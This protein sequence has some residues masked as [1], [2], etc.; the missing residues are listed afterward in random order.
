MQ[1]D[2]QYSQLNTR[3]LWFDG[4]TEITPEELPKMILSGIKPKN[5]VVTQLTP[6]IVSYNRVSDDVIGLRS[7]K[8]IDID[9]EWSIPDEYKYIDIENYLIG[10]VDKI[11]RDE[12]YD[13]RLQ[14]LS[15][16]IVLF[17]EF[18]LFDI[19][20]VLIYIVDEMK[21]KNIVW[22]IGRGSS[23]S[24]YILYLIGLHEIDVVKFDIS[25]SDFIH[26]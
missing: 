12:L 6:D 4:V 1:Q 18:N 26:T 24:S 21:N 15:E 5:I 20:K 3:K 17:S 8:S 11:D 23:C 19:L 2:L 22:G 9:S 14:R 25:I 10:L 13:Q 16:E 7:Q